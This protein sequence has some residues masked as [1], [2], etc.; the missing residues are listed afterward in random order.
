MA[1]QMKIGNGSMPLTIGRLINTEVFGGPF[2]KI[3]EY[4]FGVKMAVEIS[5]HCDVNVP[6]RDF[7]V[8]KISD[9]QKGIVQALMA[10]MNGEQVYVGCMGGIGRTGLF[11]AAL[12]KVQIEYRRAK[13]RKGRG[14]DPVL[15]VRQH[16]IPHA[17]ET[18]QQKDYIDNFDVSDIVEWLNAT[19]RAMGMGGLTP[20]RETELVKEHVAKPAW[21]PEADKIDNPAFDV[22][23]AEWKHTALVERDLDW[24]DDVDA[25]SAAEAV[26][27]DDDIRFDDLYA[28]I[29]EL[30]DRLDANTSAAIA[31][32]K[33]QKELGLSIIRA[34]T[35]KTLTKP[36]LV[37]KLLAWF[38]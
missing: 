17:V 12:A 13:H 33:E 34:L 9:L 24:I 14:D 32:F 25:D 22:Y 20:A 29:E 30:E 27:S 15:Y 23:R 36:T 19:Q 26:D 11:L 35:T 18:Q 6:T 8:P 16:F 3:P 38:K 37:G 5:Q 21:I 28:R 10:V 4:M 31:A 2:R 7:D 1:A